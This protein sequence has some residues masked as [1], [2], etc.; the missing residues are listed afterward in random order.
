MNRRTRAFVFLGLL[1]VLTVAGGV[2]AASTDGFDLGWHVVAGG[3]GTSS[4]DDFALLGTAGQPAAGV[5]TG[6]DYVLGSGFW[7]GGQ[8]A[9][10]A[11]HV[12]LPLVAR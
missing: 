1:A 4:S 5:L 7:G 8:L 10:S 6:R 11:Y 12:Y 3:G 2:L 9:A